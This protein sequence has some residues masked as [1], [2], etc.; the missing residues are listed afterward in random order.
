MWFGP[1]ADRAK[2]RQTNSDGQVGVAL[3]QPDWQSDGKLQQRIQTGML[4]QRVRPMHGSPSQ[5]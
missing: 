2:D 3:E 4:A 5:Q 1:K